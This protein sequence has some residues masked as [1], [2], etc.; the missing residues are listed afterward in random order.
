MNQNTTLHVFD[1]SVSLELAGA[2]TFCGRTP[3]AYA[4]MVGPYGG[5][6]A[7]TLLNAV[8][9][10]EERQGDPVSM[11]VNFAG[12]VGDGDFQIVA[13]ARRTNRSTQHWNVELSQQGVVAVTATVLLAVR[14]DTWGDTEVFMP[15]VPPSESVER[16]DAG[17]YLAWVRNYDFRV[18]EGHFDPAGGIEANGDSLTRLWV[19]DM[20][21]R[22]L[23]YLSLMA[24]SDCFFPR[25]FVRRQ[26]RMPVGTVSLT[27]YF[28][29]D[30]D[31]LARQGDSPVL[32][33]AHAHRYSRGF[34]DH[35]GKLWGVG[36]EL[37]ATTHQM[38]YFKD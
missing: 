25:I 19:R 6:L 30:R 4:N 9:L 22:P 15:D 8:L 11:T 3:A 21:P 12:P 17:Q 38:V 13:S 1:Q 35:T 26:Q 32:A 27:T 20:P 23:D 16:I 28:H 18:V 10:H 2:D 5:F 7:A 29:A 33:E 34:F 36:G 37:L 31:S 14:R 24:I